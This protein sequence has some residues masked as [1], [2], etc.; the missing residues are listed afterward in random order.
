[1]ILKTYDDF[2]EEGLKT[3]EIDATKFPNPNRNNPDFFI[4]GKK[5]GEIN[6]DIVHTKFTGIP[7]KQLKPSQ[8]AVYLG[9]ALGL[10]INGVVGGD[11]GAV[12]SKDNR[13][14]DGH[15]R[16]AATIFNDSNAK[17]NGVKADLNIGDLI[18]VLRAAGDALGNNRGLPPEGGDVN[19]FKATVEDVKKCCYEGT[20]MDLKYFN[21]QKAIEWFESKGEKEIKKAL[22]I[23]N[24]VG[25]PAGAPPRQEMPKIKPNQVDKVA[26]DLNAGKIDVRSPYNES[27]LPSFSE[28][29]NEN[30]FST[31]PIWSSY[32]EWVNPDYILVTLKTGKKIKIQRK[33]IKGG[34]QTYQLFL[35]AF[36]ETTGKT[37]NPKAIIFLNRALEEMLKKGITESYKGDPDIELEK[38]GKNYD[39]TYILGD[40]EINGTL[41]MNRQSK[42]WELDPEFADDKA[43]EYWDDNWEEI[44]DQII[45]ELY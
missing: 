6:D 17:V 36:D 16:W 25:P 19:I 9:K 32:E 13:I 41:K 21:K 15:H 20:Y 24:R 14:L 31:D 38:R 11:L 26:N 39:V 12:I 8:D 44:T 40:I 1:M 37:P 42:M 29:L 3:K 7:A 18:P 45:K 33:F 30:V 43:E 28:F 10:A 35:V 22:D 2:L 27:I 4:N 34:K 5:D 23:I